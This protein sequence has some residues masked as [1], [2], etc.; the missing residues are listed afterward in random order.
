M[1]LIAQSG[2]LYD[3]IV[4]VEIGKQGSKGFLLTGSGLDSYKIDFNV[5]Y[6][7]DGQPTKG[8][9]TLYNAPRRLAQDLQEGKGFVRLSAGHN[10]VSGVIFAGIPAR[11]S[12]HLTKE[13]QELVLKMDATAGGSRYRT[14][15]TSISISGE[16]GLKTLLSK[17]ISDAGWTPGVLDI[18]N[19]ARLTRN[20]VHC[21]QTQQA[22]ERVARAAQVELIFENE[23][24][25]AVPVGGSF[26]KNSERA[27]VFSSKDGTLYGTISYG[28][29]S[30]TK[31]GEQGKSSNG[32]SFTGILIPGIYPGKHV[33][34][35]YLD[36][37][38]GTWLR[39]AIVVRDITYAGGTIGSEFCVKISGV[40]VRTR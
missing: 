4:E 6:K 29:F 28:G 30:S 1:P 18:P 25:H 26:G 34:V 35:E 8:S 3:R 37:L 24:V 32:L 31:S 15:N 9:L 14:A 36:P 2:E 39:H 19:E 21:G 10:G 11:D 12:V 22:L 16:V 20:F 40:P 5:Q 23:R 33:V 27:P 17:L 7:M 38:S 13:G